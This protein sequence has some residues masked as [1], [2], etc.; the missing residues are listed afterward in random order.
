MSR[1]EFGKQTRRDAR[2]R[3][4]GYCEASGAMYGLDPGRRCNGDLSRGCEFD[5]VLA[6]SNGGDASLNNCL[7]ICR[8]CHRFKT[9]RFD[10]PR[11]AKTVRQRD[12][13]S[14]IRSRK[15]APMPGSRDSG[16]R[17]RMDGRVERR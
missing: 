10:T 4:N 13:A 11:A 8:V 15:G 7:C 1:Q 3:A 12:K 14:G 6:A 5:H 9:D 2:D 17:K 16:L